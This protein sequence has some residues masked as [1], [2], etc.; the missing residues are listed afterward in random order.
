[1]IEHL[2]L[3]G[4]LDKSDFKA[5]I[6]EFK[7]RYSIASVKLDLLFKQFEMSFF[8]NNLK[9]SSFLVNYG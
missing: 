7:D 9:Q 6:L 3:L 4:E 2:K 8:D 5:L 1:M